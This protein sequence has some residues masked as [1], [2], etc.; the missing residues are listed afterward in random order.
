MDVTGK[1]MY[2]VCMKRNE[3]GNGAI[4]DIA[5]QLRDIGIDKRIIRL[6]R[7]DARKVKAPDIH[8]EI[9][10]RMKQVVYSSGKAVLVLSKRGRYSVYT[11]DGIESLSRSAK[12][13][14]PWMSREEH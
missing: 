9:I 5:D 8:A 10:N 13:H 6:V 14:K 1:L 11:M 3:P 4:N 7:K 12:E 2:P